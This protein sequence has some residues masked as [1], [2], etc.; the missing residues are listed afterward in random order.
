MSLSELAAA[1][2]PKVR[3]SST[4]GVKKSTVCTSAVFSSIRYTP[5]SSQV[6]KPTSTFGSVWRGSC[7][8]TESSVPG[9][10]LAAQPAALAIDVNLT[11]LVI[12]PPLDIL[13]HY[14][15]DAAFLL[16]NPAHDREHETRCK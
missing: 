2:S 4:I 6:S 13:Q 7:R 11:R 5:A 3:G 9:L 15:R 10:S 8:K 16:T 1:I 12:R 14:R